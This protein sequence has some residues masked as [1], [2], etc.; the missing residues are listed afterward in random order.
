MT[1]TRTL[2]PEDQIGQYRV[3]GPLG[4]G[5][6]G[7][8]Y[9]AQ[10][11]TLE[12]NVALKVLPPEL[13]R[14]EDRVRRFM[15]EAKSASS[16]N[17][18]NIITIYEIG[19]ERVRSAAGAES[20]PVQY[21]S[22]ELVSGKTLASKIHEEKTDLRTLLGYLAQAAEGIAKAHA[23]GI[24]H[25]DLKPGNIM[26]SDD[27]FAKV[28][29]FGLAKLTEKSATASATAATE[30]AERTSAGA[31][32]GT[33]GYMS[34][35]QVQGKVVDSRSDI[36]SFGCILHEAA[37]GRRPFVAESNVETMHKIIHEKPQPIEEL[38]PAVPAELRRLIRR[39]LA[40]QP[41]QR[42]QS[43]KDLAI[44][45]REIV[46]EFDS[47][48]A[49]TTSASGSTAAVPALPS[50]RAPL[51]PVL[52]VVSAVAVAALVFGWWS[53]KRGGGEEG[54]QPFQT[55]RI[56]TQTS[57][58]DVIDC[59]I[60]PDGRYLAY[61][62]GKA[63]QHTL[64]VRQVATGSDVEIL[65]VQ[66][67]NMEFPGFSPDGNYIFYCKRRADAPN[68][69]VLMSVP[70][71]G[72]REQERGFDVDSR[73]AFSPDGKR[74]CFVRGYPQKG[75]TALMVL[76]LDTGKEHELVALPG[77]GG[78]G[79]APSWSP[80]GKL[81]AVCVI[82]PPPSS[83]TTVVLFDA[84]S[85]D[86]RDFFTR[87]GG[88]IGSVAWLPDGKGMVLAGFDL[89][90]TLSN[91]VFLLTYPAGKLGRV[92]NDFNNYGAVTAG[93]GEEAIAS[94]RSSG[95]YNIH[96][97][98]IDGNQVRALTST[99]SPENSPIGVVALADRVLLR[100]LHR[101]FLGV[102][103]L[104][105]TGGEVTPFE[106]GSGHVVNMDA[107]PERIVFQRLDADQQ[108]H[109]WRMDPSG[110]GMRQLT[111]GGGEAL[112]DLSPDGKLITFAKS[113]STR[114]VWIMPTDGGEARLL[115]ATAT[116]GI[117]PFAMGGLSV[118]TVE[119]EADD[120]GLIRI[121]FK[122]V[123][124]E[125][126]GEVATVRLPQQSVDYEELPGADAVTFLDSADPAS[127]ISR[128]DVPSGART[129]V[130]KF[131]EGRVA[132]HQ[133]SPD[134]RRVAMVR[135]LPEGENAWVMNADGTQ[136]KQLTRFT[137]LDIIQMDWTP[138]GRRVVVNAGQSSS[139]VALIR[140]FR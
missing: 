20:D 74:A 73:L 102:S 75:Y 81:I 22:M 133:W 52:V 1:T 48:S 54:A 109:V 46:E 27:G 88:F 101:Q 126:E 2:Q 16:L 115:S 34:P 11:Q 63:G 32:L 80:D 127:N 12:R 26:V 139:D 118:V 6:M 98:D 39:A 15:Q 65:P 134:G 138:D 19:Q 106:T 42:L 69:R 61:V 90:T 38:N 117:A 47:L 136:L 53:L 85:G 97:V 113:D 51:V 72:G 31:V 43:M 107:T 68:Y 129:Q 57:R 14:S 24:I 50:R 45:L 108:M 9:L 120:A 25:R 17:H 30:V 122:V 41:D 58:G 66:N 135:R 49:S 64:R 82:V 13:V 123:P 76:D 29:D 84:A 91:Q 128:I 62:A 87:E 132:D 79:G 131:R 40:K 56:A 114:G 119:Y 95:L 104:P 89:K 78:P 111:K 100:R 28:L 10:D 67:A 124:V 44:E 70:S 140:D 92:T 59:A 86:R 99:T 60:S 33:V 55:M 137:G 83:A 93:A 21:I 4:A 130:S 8:V 37:T 96:V 18:P 5:G 77:P 116:P 36:F 71:L 35:E 110:A 121:V 105:L 7:E 94:N 3:V 125:G 23:A 112:L 103:S